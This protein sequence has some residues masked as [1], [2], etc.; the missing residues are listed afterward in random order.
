MLNELLHGLQKCDVIR[1]GDTVCCAVSG[2]A[3]SMALL[4]GLYL[5]KDKLGITLRAAHFNHGLRGAESD[6]DAAFVKDFCDGYQIPLHLGSGQ[7]SAGEK[8]LEA[9]A[10]EARYGFLNTLPGWIATAHTADDNA[11]TLL[12]HLIRGTGL[13]GLGGI[14]PVRGK[15]IRPMLGI[16]RRQ[17]MDF[18][19]E[20][21]IPHVEDSSNAGDD[22]LRNR[23][24]HHVMPLLAAENPRLAENL[25]A[26]AQRLREDAQQLRQ[27]A[28]YEALP[29]VQTL[30]QR[31]PSI[32]SRM[33]E[34]FL[35]ENGVKEPSAEH[36]AL[37]EALVFSDNP[38][39]RGVFPG[40]VIITRQYDRLAA[41]QNTVPLETV[42]LPESGT[43]ELPGF[44]V[45][46]AP[47][48]ALLNTTD[49]FTV[50][51]AGGLLLR[52]RQSGDAISLSGGSRSLKKLFIDR[53]I[54][55]AMRQRIPVICDERGILGIYGIGADIRRKA[56]ALPA[57]TIHIETL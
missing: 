13:N 34:Q 5:L 23:I 21:G 1:P 41:D 49:T 24:R 22:F 17:I 14:A 42:H 51:P 30:R 29:D 53:K 15:L 44:R 54:P 43:L 40:G 7:V 20:Y 47:A 26:T 33:L 16:T 39:A 11:E 2:G 9:A 12:M 38:S 46:C 10:R 37:A 6:R 55:A 32:R 52:S 35:T 45:T 18:L 50:N 8:G 4:W 56:V 3:D 28:R 31:S 57:I 48:T 27:D 36:I 25:S 19:K